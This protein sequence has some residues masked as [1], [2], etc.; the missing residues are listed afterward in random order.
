MNEF[1]QTLELEFQSNSDPS[2]AAGQ[3][4]YM[5]NQFE[6][7]GIK[8]PKR[9]EIQR[10]FLE[11]S[12]LPPKVELQLIV[13]TLWQK[14][15]REYQYFAQELVFKYRTQFDKN[16]IVLL[17]FMATHK[18]WWDTVD[19]IAVKLIGPY[20]E[21]YP[22]Q[23]DTYIEKWLA[24]DNI[25]LQ[26]CCL[27]YQLK[28]KDK[29]DAQRLEYIIKRLLGSKEFFINKAIGWVLREYSKTNPS[30]VKNFTQLND[31]SSLSRRE[32]LRLMD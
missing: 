2:I 26:R 29:I 14:P 31:L 22:G 16:D 21:Y 4:A 32:A 25:W 18:S 10:P 13:K 11:K 23:L 27:L 15:Q 30:W 19:Y 8:N 20:F 28:R 9:R 5:R 1:I 7:Y 6:F 12:Y 17:E 24:S 3:K